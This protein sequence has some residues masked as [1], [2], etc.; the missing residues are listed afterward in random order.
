MNKGGPHV[1]I[2]A[3]KGVKRMSLIIPHE[4]HQDFKAACAMEGKG[5]T[6]VL[7][8]FVAQFVQEHLPAARP[9]KKG[10]R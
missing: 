9:G 7:L 10:G 5:M 4:L 1:S 2:T 8:E 3:K 6:K